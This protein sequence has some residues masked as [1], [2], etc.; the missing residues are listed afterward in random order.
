MSLWWFLPPL[1]LLIGAMVAAVQV[2]SIR[3]QGEQLQARARRVG[4]LQPALVRV[5]SDVEELRASLREN[6]RQ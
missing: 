1:V 4:D 3:R 2:R 5:R 6:P